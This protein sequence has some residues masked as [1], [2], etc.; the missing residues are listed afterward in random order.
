MTD[1]HSGTGPGHVERSVGDTAV[2]AL[3]GEI[4]IAAVPRLA[5]LLDA[6][7]AAPRPDVVVDLRAMSFI[8]RAGLRVLCRA[9]SRVQELD[10]CLRLVTADARFRWI[11]RHSGL[12]DAFE[13]HTS[14]TQAPRAVRAAAGPPGR[15]TRRP[16][17]R[18][19]RPS[20]R[21]RRAH[22]ATGRRHLRRRATAIPRTTAR[23]LG[24]TGP[25]P[26]PTR[27]VDRGEALTRSGEAVGGRRVVRP[28]LG[29]LRSG[30]RRPPG[31][32]RAASR[33][34]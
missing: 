6:V 24:A 27:D 3:H 7:T 1:E 20:G 4:D 23:P 34:G 22:A 25:P 18:P 9:R 32:P 30:G 11:L 28:P 26:A 33:R 5:A 14:L 8:D 2:L 21:C 13:V 12:A 17:D 15:P 10:G 29:R 16:P 31:S 19:G